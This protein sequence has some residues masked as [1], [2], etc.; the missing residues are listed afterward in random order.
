MH[1]TTCIKKEVGETP[2]EALERYRSAHPELRSVPMAYAGRLDPMASGALLLLIGDACKEQKR[3]HALDKKYEVSILFGVRS[4]TGDVLGRLRDATFPTPIKRETLIAAV[5]KFSN[6]IVTFPY[7]MFSAKTVRG[8]P[9]HQWALEDRVDDITIPTYTARIY[10]LSLIDFKTQSLENVVRDA[11]TKIETIPTVTDPKKALGA[12][13]RRDDIRT[14]WNTLLEH[15]GKKTVTIA[16][17]RCVSGSGIY[18]RTLAE[19]IGRTVG[20]PALAY[21]IHRT[22]IG[23]YMPLLHCTGVWIQ[24]HCNSR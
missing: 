5:D 10:T 4:D 12:D 23:T 14:D 9:L 19:A 2:K 16:R 6:S 13:F 7:P 3:Y 17:I 20:V 11:L 18:M 1:S 21:S 15:S 24:T 22:R 8:K